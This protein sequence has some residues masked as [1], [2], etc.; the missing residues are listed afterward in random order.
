MPSPWSIINAYP[1]PEI[2]SY[3]DGKDRINVYVDLK[4]VMT[5]LF[6]P[7][8]EQEMILNTQNLGSIDSS[9][10]QAC[11]AY[12]SY[13][14]KLAY[15]NGLVCN[16]FFCADIGRSVYHL[17]L[18]KEYKIRRNIDNST[19]DIS[20]VLTDEL[21]HIRD[22]NFLVC[23]NILNKI[24]GIY[25]FN[26]KFLEADF[27]CHYLITR[28]FDN[29]K[30]FHVVVSS[31]KDLMQTLYKPNVVMI[32]KKRGQKCILDY[33]NFMRTYL[34]LSKCSEKVQRDKTLKLSRLDSRYITAAMAL[35]GDDGDDI[36]GVRGI[37]PG[38]A[39]D[40]LSN[41]NLTRAIIGTPEELDERIANDG[42]FFLEDRIGI[43]K[44]PKLWRKVFLENEIVTRAYKLIS[45]EMLIRWLQMSDKT[46]KGDW[47]R[48][49]DDLLEKKDIRLIPTLKS[50]MYG[51]RSI[52]DFQLGEEDLLPLFKNEYF[53]MLR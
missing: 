22:K 21:K 23:D 14:K 30:I 18:L 51:I 40:I 29:D 5:A 34:H 35:V 43:S 45:F 6:I 39:I 25:F 46:E 19:G 31:D 1:P 7:E 33:T 24:D 28:K 38:R 15:R 17:S 12:A 47:L 41:E 9:I 20:G 11:L 8:V 16:I 36:P 50:F 2:Q 13:W 37:G 42:K 26:L 4:N 32:H 27:L 10:F 44:L 53:E 3:L 49:I 48:Y 52:P